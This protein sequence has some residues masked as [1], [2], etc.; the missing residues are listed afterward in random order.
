MLELDLTLRQKVYEDLQNY[1]VQEP[2][3]ELPPLK[4]LQNYDEC[5]D[6]GPSGLELLSKSKNTIVIFYEQII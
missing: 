2:Y 3:K 5:E 1:Y 4:G 6:S